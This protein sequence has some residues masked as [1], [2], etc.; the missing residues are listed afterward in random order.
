MKGRFVYIDEEIEQLLGFTREEL[1]GK[2]IIDF[3]DQQS[4]ELIEQM[5]SKRNHYETFFDFTILN[6]INSKQQKI[7]SDVI[8]SLNFI[9]GNPVNFQL[10]LN[11]TVSGNDKQNPSSEESKLL[12]FLKLINS[13]EN[14]ND[15]NDILNPMLDLSGAELLAI[16]DISTGNIEP[17]TGIANSGSIEFSFDTIP[18]LSNL[19]YQIKETQNDFSFVDQDDIRM[20]IENFNEAPNEFVTIK[21]I[22][23]AVCLIRYIYSEETDVKEVAKFIEDTTLALDL[24]SKISKEKIINNDS[25]D[26]LP[27]IKFTIGFLD[28]LNIGALL[29]NEKGDLAGYN[30]NF[31]SLFNDNEIQGD[32]SAVLNVLKE[33]N[34]VQ[35]IEQIE[36]YLKAPLDEE[37]PDDLQVE[38]QCP[39]NDKRRLTVI[40]FSVDPSDQSGCFVFLPI[41]P[42]LSLEHDDPIDNKSLKDFSISI[43][44]L[45]SS[46]KSLSDNVSRNYSN[47]LDKSGTERVA[48]LRTYAVSLKEAVNRFNK[49]INLKQSANKL[50][51]TDLTILSKRILDMIHLEY[52][53]VK[54]QS[55]VNPLPKIV[56]SSKIINEVFESIIDNS[57]KYCNDNSVTI[58][59]STETK[60]NFCFIKIKDNGKGIPKNIRDKIFVQSQIDSLSNMTHPMLLY[61]NLS[62]CKQLMQVLGGD[63]N[64]V[65]SNKDGTLF[66]IKT[67]IG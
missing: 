14:F 1:F 28:S 55:K 37:H 49:I 29:T 47:Q 61:N 45:V 26:T 33:H 44:G 51:L 25:V 58:E 35:L 66:E 12:P 63:L 39:S 24:I 52:P 30:P 19:H 2:N 36:E 64:L 5:L 6:V 27:D 17:L 54:I 53:G 46:V 34:P 20:A 59:I 32:I 10:I 15:L 16:Y 11:Q 41:N 57:V 31:I 23:G 8:I 60:E 50:Y 40:K 62:I 67:P 42:T 18:P 13:H 22:S 43:K 3:V 21:E 4:A 65:S 56:T 9:A 38:I 48:N 7:S